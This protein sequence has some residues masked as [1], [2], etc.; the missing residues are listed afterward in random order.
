M[1]SLDGASLARNW[2]P[3]MTRQ[4]QLLD[5]AR[6]TNATRPLADHAQSKDNAAASFNPVETGFSAVLTVQ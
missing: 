1:E 6:G 5:G 4:S 3:G 2:Q